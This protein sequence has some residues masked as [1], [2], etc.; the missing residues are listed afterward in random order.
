MIDINSGVVVYDKGSF[1]FRPSSDLVKV[2]EGKYKH[3]KLNITVTSSTPSPE[4]VTRFVK[5]FHE[6]AIR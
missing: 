5:A 1:L 4:A 3:G 6:L 2:G